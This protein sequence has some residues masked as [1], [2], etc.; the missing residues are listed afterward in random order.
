M[1]K[2][3]HII[4]GLLLIL[5]G[6]TEPTGVLEYDYTKVFT[7]G[8]KKSWKIRTVEIVRSG[9]G[10]LTIPAEYFFDDEDETCLSDDVYTFFANSERAYQ[11]TEGATKCNDTDPDIKYD[12]SWSFV[13]SAAVLTIKV[14]ALYEDS[15]LPFI[16]YTAN[17]NELV[18]DIYIDELN[19]NNYRLN[20]RPTGTD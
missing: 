11:V 10:T 15:A 18:L 2:T 5:S 1:L 7:G 14:P 19:K 13:N 6:C 20:F 8:D 16:V 3:K 9:K 12:G 17:D 4:V